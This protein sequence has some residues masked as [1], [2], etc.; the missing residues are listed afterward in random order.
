METEASDAYPSG[1]SSWEGIEDMGME[2]YIT[3]QDTMQVLHV[4]IGLS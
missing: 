1:N 2:G 3:C 4:S